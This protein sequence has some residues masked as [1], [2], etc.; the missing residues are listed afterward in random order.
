MAVVLL[1]V[2]NVVARARH[3]I[4]HEILEDFGVP[5]E[6]ARQV[7][8]LPQYA[9]FSRGK[10]GGEDWYNAFLAT[11]PQGT[12]GELLLSDFRTA[13]DR[14]I[15]DIDTGVLR[16]FLDLTRPKDN[17]IAVAT[18]TN[19]WQT[20]VIETELSL[21]LEGLAAYGVYRSDQIRMLKQD[22]GYFEHVLA[23][24]ERQKGSPLGPENVYLVDD[25][26]ANLEI[27]GRLG[28]HPVFYDISAGIPQ[29]S[30][31]LQLD[32]E[33]RGLL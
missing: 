7:F 17:R 33:V 27:A 24:I 8:N 11:L 18:N 23:Q 12:Q 3:S 14:H 21:D 16:I 22:P 13:H 20:Q 2:G 31:K 4:A 28:I 6:A 19:G 32:L 15:Y 9:D 1:D 26:Q 30:R 5:R 10:I 25:N 29:A